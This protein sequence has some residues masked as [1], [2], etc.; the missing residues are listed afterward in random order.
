[1]AGK[2]VADPYSTQ[3]GGKLG[4]P[5]VADSDIAM[6]QA[7]SNTKPTRPLGRMRRAWRDITASAKVRL[8]GTLRPDLPGPDLKRLIRQIDE[9][10]EGRGGEISARARAADLGRT[11]L[12]LNPLGR[13]RFLRLLA[14]EYDVDRE[15]L[16]EEA[17]DYCE[18]PY[19]DATENLRA[20]ETRIRNL[21][22]PPRV[23]LLARFNSLPGG[24]KFLVD[25]RA[26]L[27]ELA[28]EDR[29]LT[30]L[31]DDLRRLLASW[32]DV[33]FLELR[34]ITWDAP[35]S[36]LEKLALHEAVHRITSW[37][38]IK[39][40]LARDRRCYAFFHDQMPDEPLIYMWVAL[41]NGM[42]DNVQE[43]LDVDAP[44]GDPADADTAIFYSITHAQ[45][46]LAGMSFGSFL[47]KRVVEH[48]ERDFH[49]LKT[50]ATLSPVPGFSQWLEQQI[51]THDDDLLETSELAAFDNAVPGTRGSAALKAALG[52]EHWYRDEILSETIR[53]VLT[54]LCAV[55]LLTAKHGDR[56]L[57]RVAHFHLSNGARVERINWL[58]DTSPAGL[59]QSYGMMVNYLYK[60]REIEDNHE[61]YRGEGKIRASAGVRGLLRAR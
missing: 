48:L 3:R 28:R 34:C 27:I 21:L 20:S 61:A 8:T 7:D 24:V 40:R 14:E 35:A 53:P 49:H 51:A 26:E 25:L 6:D 10:L 32:F 2:K 18:R 57:D 42:S 16:R 22:L 41:V 37:D 50:F 23:H 31:D 5:G 44:T 39:N 19:T 15:A 17:S 55:Y 52:R 4:C 11:Y 58:G 9:F 33:G 60:S 38:D 45:A 1:M 46:G 59:R 47:I 36:L 43:L 29:A 54:R 12:S 56:A 30:G 13:E